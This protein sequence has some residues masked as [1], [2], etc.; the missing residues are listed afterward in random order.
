MFRDIAIFVG[1]SLLA[2]GLVVSPSVTEAQVQSEFR[3]LQTNCKLALLP[4]AP[5]LTIS[6][7]GECVSGVAKGVGDVIAFS[8]GKL[9]YILRGQFS[10]G[11]LE[12]TDRIRYC[13]TESCTDDVPPA[14]VRRHQVESVDASV[15]APAIVSRVSG[16]APSEIR[17]PDGVYRGNVS[18]DARTGAISGEVRVEYFDG[19]RFEGTLIDGRKQGYGTHIWADGQKYSGVWKDDI[20]D[21]RGTFTFANGD[22]YEG[23]FVQG[24][25]TGQG[26]LKQAA[27]GMYAGQ[28][29]RGSR[30]GRGVAEW[31]NGQRY[32]GSWRNNQKHGLGL[33]RFADGGSY[34]GDWKEDRA[35]GQGDI[36]FASGDVYAGQVHDG[37]PHGTGLFRWGSGDRFEG[38]FASGKPTTKGT[39]TFLA[40]AV[41]VGISPADIVPVL[42]STEPAI[43]IPAATSRITLCATAFNSAR[44]LATVRRFLDSFPDDECG[45]HV[46]ARQKIAAWEEQARAANRAIEERQAAAKA[47]IGAAVAFK[48][49]F[50]FC[51]VSAASNAACQRITYVFDVRARIR[52]IDLQRRLVQV[53]VTDATS[54]GNEKGAPT[55]LFSEGRGAAAAAYK[56][57][58]VGSTVSKTLTEV[59]LVF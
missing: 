27:G 11:L 22:V 53:Q 29:T 4:T 10:Q 18:V 36:V 13:A 50:P 54:L 44:N 34:D 42:P 2:V 1:I 20:Q 25:R 40:E 49:E 55:Q 35:D 52:E 16:T 7:T 33:M 41:S 46:L 47:F 31:V 19:R 28:W 24:E 14:L 21:G 8:G 58:M 43:P 39:M 59:G 15:A 30:D 23:D 6:W 38:E 32:D 37:E 26:T 57:R 45:R 48:Q 9:H 12:R 56:S 3:D 5:K 17:A 51:V